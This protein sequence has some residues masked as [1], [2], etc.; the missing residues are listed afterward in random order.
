MGLGSLTPSTD[1]IYIKERV[2]E[3]RIAELDKR[4]NMFQTMVLK[5]RVK[6]DG[7]IRKLKPEFGR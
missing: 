2:L 1:G 7:S 3:A 6:N 4:V 5:E